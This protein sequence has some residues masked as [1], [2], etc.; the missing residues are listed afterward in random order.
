MGIGRMRQKQ[1]KGPDKG[2]FSPNPCFFTN[3][4]SSPHTSSYMSGHHPATVRLA[5]RKRH[6]RFES[7][8][9][10]AEL[11]AVARTAVELHGCCA[12]VSL[13]E[14]LLSQHIDCVARAGSA[15]TKSGSSARSLVLLTM[16]APV[17]ENR[18]VEGSARARRRCE[19]ANRR[20]RCHGAR[21]AAIRGGTSRLSAIFSQLPASARSS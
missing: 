17:V 4:P 11:P 5:G 18:T 13:A 1:N 6:A 15:G 21:A 7:S 14:A 9:A 20:R 19:L 12:R 2:V 16:L 3:V 8:E 10:L